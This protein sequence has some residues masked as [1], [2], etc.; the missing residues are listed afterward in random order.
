[1]TKLIDLLQNPVDTKNICQ[2]RVIEADM[3]IDRTIDILEGKG[4]SFLYKDR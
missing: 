4:D 2:R 3:C 1:M